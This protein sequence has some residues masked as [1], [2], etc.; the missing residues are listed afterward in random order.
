IPPRLGSVQ[1]TIPTAVSTLPQRIS[2]PT[3]PFARERY[4]IAPPTVETCRSCGRLHG[5][6]TRQFSTEEEAQTVLLTPGW[7]EET[8]TRVHP[9]E[10]IPLPDVGTGMAQGTIPTGPSLVLL[11]DLPSIES[12]HI[13]ARLA[14][15]GICRNLHSQQ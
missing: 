2:L 11:Y 14:S 4:W 9:S 5:L 6:S 15:G 1:G 8:I 12:S 7:K 3:Y 10:E 13:Q